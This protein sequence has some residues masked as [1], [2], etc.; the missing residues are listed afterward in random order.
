[1]WHRFP[2]V[3]VAHAITINKSGLLMSHLRSFNRFIL[4]SLALLGLSISSTNASLIGNEVTFESTSTGGGVHP[5]VQASATVGAGAEFNWNPAFTAAGRTG[6]VDVDFGAET[7]DLIFSM[8]QS[9]LAVGG[10]TTLT[11]TDLDWGVPGEL[12]GVTI[13]ED[14]DYSI[15]SFNVFTIN[16][17]G[18]TAFEIVFSTFAFGHD[19]PGASSDT[20]RLGL[21]TVHINPVPVPAAVWLFGTALIGFVGMS[22]RRKVA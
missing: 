16:I 10:T 20:L 17:L 5:F 12:T 18:P 2:A 22:R 8:D 6:T 21:D 4:V 7:L 11:F 14:F 15:Y 13:L 19:A 3:T 9:N 1:M